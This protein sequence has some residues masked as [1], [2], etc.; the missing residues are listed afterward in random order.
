MKTRGGKISQQLTPCL[1]TEAHPRQRE[2]EGDERHP[3][4]VDREVPGPAQR[5]ADLGGCNSPTELIN[6]KYS[7]AVCPPEGDSVGLGGSRKL[8]RVQAA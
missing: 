7:W 6:K 5:A 4:T 3:G 1:T 2:A 8:P